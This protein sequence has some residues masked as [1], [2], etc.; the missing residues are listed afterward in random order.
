[1]ENHCASVIALPIVIA[2]SGCSANQ[3]SNAIQA[4]SVPQPAAVTPH[5]TATHVAAGGSKLIYTLL[6]FDKNCRPSEPRLTIEQQPAKGEV[7]FKPIPMATV[8]SSPSGHCIGKSM[9][10]TAVVYTPRNGQTG[11]DRFAIAAT[12]LSGEI[13]TRSF[14]VEI[15]E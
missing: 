4:G 13:G 14:V 1:M 15:T 3:T 2:L 10:G 9:R 12:S 8:L 11:I 6:S 7:S 5:V